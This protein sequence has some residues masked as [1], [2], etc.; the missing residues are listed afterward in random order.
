MKLRTFGILA[1]L[2]CALAATQA[3][4]S[5]FDAHPKLVVVIVVDQL[6]PDLL[7]RNHARFRENGFRMLTDRGAYFLSCYYDY[8][9]TTTAPGHATLLSGSYSDGHGILANQWW[10]PAKKK[11]VAAV[12][13]DS[14]TLVGPV[15]KAP[16][17]SPRHLLTST[18]GD[19]LKLAT[20]GRSRVFSTSLKDRSAVFSAGFA[21]DGVYWMDPASGAWITSSYYASKLPGWVERF[22]SD[23]RTEKYW[24]LEW[25]DGS[26]K[27]LRSTRRGPESRF[28]DV[29]GVTP[30]AIEYQLE[31]ARELITQEK[32]GGGSATDLLVL[33]LSSPDLLGHQAGPD[34]P[35][36]S[37]ILLDLDTKLEEFFAFLG[38]QI[39]LANVWIALAADHGIAPLPADAAKVRL[40]AG[41]GEYTGLKER[42]N[43]ALAAQFHA[44]GE[45]VAAVHWPQVFLS[46]EAFQRLKVSQ[47][48]AERAVGEA[49]VRMGMRAYYTKSRLARGEMPP[50]EEGRRYLHSYSPHSGW[51]VLGVPRPFH[52]PDSKANHGTGYSYD[53][54]VPLALFGLPFQAGHYRTPAEPVDLAVT[55]ASLLGI[56]S[57][58]SAQGRV[59][60]EALARH[61]KRP[62]APV[63]SEV[64]R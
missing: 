61:P 39:G 60:A 38:R 42:L 57:P 51:Y 35:E 36:I 14:T 49:L 26:G 29:V 20:R 37:Q 7:E 44:A 27:L 63:T 24:N 33:G 55:L 15:A 46:S 12:S 30:F 54:H 10:D 1:P 18:L 56:S 52:S 43:A 45:Y 11:S 21:A 48:E 50:D 32:L 47:A 9:N 25:K 22:N 2:V 4:A 8:A 28:A 23:K 3:L 59:L 34:S 58:A 40:P 41:S 53:R 13:D 19:E 5:A 16:G 31:F 62:A 6:R 17:A 64:K